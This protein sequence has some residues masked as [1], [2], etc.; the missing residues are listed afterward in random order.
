MAM[1]ISDCTIHYPVMDQILAEAEW[2][3]YEPRQT[4]ARG[5]VVCAGRGN[6]KTSLHNLIPRHFHGY[7][8]PHLPLV[9]RIST[10]GHSDAR[11][12]HVRNLED[13]RSTRHT[14]H[15]HTT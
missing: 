4:R 2:M 6:G 1:V 5:L 7:D 9:V 3:V 15:R 12:L 10:C 8:D 11:S 13:F 14:A